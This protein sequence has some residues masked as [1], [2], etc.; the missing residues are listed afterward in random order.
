MTASVTRL[1]LKYVRGELT[2]I[3]P[4]VKVWGAKKV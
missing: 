2:M 3:S 1:T 4:S